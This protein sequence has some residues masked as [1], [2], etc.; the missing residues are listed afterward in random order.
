MNQ[1]GAE[2][3]LEHGDL[4]S[5]GRLTN[6]TFLCDSGE[7]PSFNYPHENLQCIEFVHDTRTI[8]LC[9]PVYTGDGDS[10]GAV[11]FFD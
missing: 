3:V 7:A 9:T 11:R 10:V 1:L 6:S 4:F 2:F 5:D 8:P